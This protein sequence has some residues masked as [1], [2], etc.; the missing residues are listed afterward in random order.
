VAVT[1]VKAA[2]GASVAVVDKQE[3]PAASASGS[4]SGGG[5][6]SKAFSL[7][8]R[9]LSGRQTASGTPTGA[10]AGASQQ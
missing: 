10:T 4:S 1:Q 6:G 3:L 5:G 7:F 2:P 8:K 9:K